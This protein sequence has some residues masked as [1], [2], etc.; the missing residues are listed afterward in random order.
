MVTLF[1]Y[2]VDDDDGKLVISV[3]GKVAQEGLRRLHEHVDAGGSV[4]LVTLLAPLDPLR[5]LLS[6]QVALS[7]RGLVA[8]VD[9]TEQMLS[10]AVDQTL[11]DFRQQLSDFQ[12]T[13]GTLRD[14]AS[15]TEDRPQTTVESS[16]GKASKETAAKT[17]AK[18]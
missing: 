8:D 9:D 1:G 5:G 6:A 11:T 10:Q 13:L 14:Q 18:P 4:P 12:G 2:A 16:S 15:A 7:P 17:D 3:H